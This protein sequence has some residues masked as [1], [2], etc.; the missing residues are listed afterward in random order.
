MLVELGVRPDSTQSKGRQLNVYQEFFE[1]DFLSH[2][3]RYYIGESASFLA[4]NPVT[5]YL[6]KVTNVQ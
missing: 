1:T 4:I 5:E 6:K 2:T 3:E